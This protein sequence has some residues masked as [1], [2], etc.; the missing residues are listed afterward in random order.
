MGNRI[1]FPNPIFKIFDDFNFRIDD[2]IILTFDIFYIRHGYACWFD[3]KFFGT[4]AM[5]CL[6]TS[7][8]S[9]G[10]HWYQSRCLFKKPIALNEG[11][12]ITGTLTFVANAHSSFEVTLKCEING[13]NIKAMNVIQLHDQHYEYLQQAFE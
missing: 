5:I 9:E 10:T 6:T 13:C 3:V 4:Q 2:L 12:K 7:P 11:Q 8:H 1:T